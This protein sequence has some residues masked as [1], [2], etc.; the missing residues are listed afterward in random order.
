LRTG[1]CHCYFLSPVTKIIY[2]NNAIELMYDADRTISIEQSAV[3]FQINFACEDC[4]LVIA[5]I[6]A[7]VQLSKQ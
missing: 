3:V 5:P 2:T 7:N 4:R 6:Y 1:R